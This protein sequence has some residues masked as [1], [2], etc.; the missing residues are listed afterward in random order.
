MAS[1]TSSRLAVTS[2]G[3]SEVP[4]AAGFAAVPGA[5][6]AFAAPASAGAGRKRA[7]TSCTK[8]ISRSFWRRV[9]SLAVTVPDGI[10]TLTG[11]C[12]RMTCSLVRT[13]AVA[14]RALRPLSAS[15]S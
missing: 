4:K 1:A 5:A 7:T 14:S 12:D 8:V 6:L 15:T 11:S 3:S 9:I 13:S 2:M 10:V